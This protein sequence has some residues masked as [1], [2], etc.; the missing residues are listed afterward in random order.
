MTRKLLHVAHYD[1]APFGPR[2]S[3]NASALVYSRTGQRPLE[4]AE[5]ELAAALGAVEACPPEAE[6]VVQQGRKVGHSGYEVF[7]AL[8]QRLGDGQQLAVFLF[9][10]F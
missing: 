2:G 8:H 10:H 6:L 9:F 5:D 4:G 1:G 7:F 3:A